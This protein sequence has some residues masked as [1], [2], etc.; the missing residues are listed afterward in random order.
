[1]CVY[2]CVYVVGDSGLSSLGLPDPL[3][4]LRTSPLTGRWCFVYV[5]CVR[6]VGQG[7]GRDGRGEA[8]LGMFRFIFGVIP[9]SCCLVLLL[10]C[11][12]RLL[13]LLAYPPPGNF[14]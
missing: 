9:T 6:T 14:C 8:G 10:V 5:L 11:L 12:Q 13:L 4:C 1:V 3:W 7:C 2:V